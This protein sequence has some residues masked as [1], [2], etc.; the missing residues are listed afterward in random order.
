MEADKMQIYK[1]NVAQNMKL[2]L[3]K[4]LYFN[5]DMIF[6]INIKRQKNN[7]NYKKC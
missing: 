2:T 5:N 3:N 1:I 6:N 7:N 4:N